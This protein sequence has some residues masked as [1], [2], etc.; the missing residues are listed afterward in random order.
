MS[1]SRQLRIPPSAYLRI[2]ASG[3]ATKYA[4]GQVITIY[5]RCIESDRVLRDA[6]NNRL[7][8][9]VLCRSVVTLNDINFDPCYDAK[10]K[11]Y[12]YRLVAGGLR[13]VGSRQNV[14]YISKRLNVA[15]MQEA[16]DHLM[17]PPTTKDFSSF[18]PHKAGDGEH[19]NVCTI[20]KIKLHLETVDNEKDVQY[21][22]DV[23]TKIRLCF[24]GDRFRYR[25]R[26]KVEEWLV[27]V[28]LHKLLYRS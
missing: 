18:T 12:E 26:L 2:D 10:C 14:W 13:P 5:S 15:K 8:Q 24:E 28:H 23:A 11:R 6:L 25:M 7:P 20:S 22:E 21:Q 19:D 27:K 16:I 1:G 4:N 17:A 9:D 3:S